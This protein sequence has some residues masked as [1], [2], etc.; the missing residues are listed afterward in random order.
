MKWLI[1]NSAIVAFYLCTTSI[2]EVN[3]KKPYKIKMLELNGTQISNSIGDQD[4]E[5]D[6]EDIIDRIFRS[7][8][9]ILTS[10]FKNMPSIAEKV[11]LFVSAIFESLKTY[12]EGYKF[13]KDLL[14]SPS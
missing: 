2:V 1:L 6:L 9:T 5:P 11:F 10:Q 8:L 3:T 7:Y 4:Y 12:M 14:K 13:M